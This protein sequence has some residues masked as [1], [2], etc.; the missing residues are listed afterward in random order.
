MHFLYR[1]YLEVV[2]HTELLHEYSYLFEIMLTLRL[3]NMSEV[4]THHFSMRNQ[5]TPA[6]CPLAPFSLHFLNCLSLQF[7][8]LPFNG[9]RLCLLPLQV[10]RCEEITIFI[11]VTVFIVIIVLEGRGDMLLVCVYLRYRHAGNDHNSIG[12]E[13]RVFVTGK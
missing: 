5:L 6:A 9:P 12:E 2:L 10:N 8:F 13:P 4:V 7:S 1:L 3:V 11:F